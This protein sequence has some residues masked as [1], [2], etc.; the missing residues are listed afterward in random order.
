[1]MADVDQNTAGSQHVVVTVEPGRE[2]FS[3]SLKEPL[4]RAPPLSAGLHYNL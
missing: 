1:M 4:D 2:T 3:D